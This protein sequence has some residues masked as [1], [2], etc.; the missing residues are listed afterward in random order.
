FTKLRFVQL[1]GRRLQ[2]VA[3]LGERGQRLA[4]PRELALA[5]AQRRQRLRELRAL[6]LE[7]TQPVERRERRAVAEQ[8][9]VFV[10]AVEVQELLAEALQVRERHG[11]LVDARAT[12]PLGAH[13]AAGDERL[14]VE[15]EAPLLE[16]RSRALR[17]V[18]GE[19]ELGL[20]DAGFRTL[21]DDEG[22]G[23][24]ADDQRERFHGER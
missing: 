18:A 19:V 6:G 11:R 9:L 14:A 20:D 13:L 7:P 2:V 12:A 16:Q 4:Q 22:I 17:A 8:A 1:G 23:A 5:L 3:A 15:L 10:L 21:A 24:A